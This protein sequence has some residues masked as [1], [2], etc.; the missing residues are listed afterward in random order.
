MTEIVEFDDDRHSVEDV[1]RGHP[2][3]GDTE[4]IE[5]E[6]DGESVEGGGRGPSASP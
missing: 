6:R 2:H 5:P 1:E 3:E 4:D